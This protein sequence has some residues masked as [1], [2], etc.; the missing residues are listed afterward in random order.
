MVWGKDKG[1]LLKGYK[2]S[3]Q[4]EIGKHESFGKLIMPLWECPFS[5]SII[6]FI[7]FLN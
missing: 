1:Y 7:D 5:K 2:Q 3:K 4:S 6:S